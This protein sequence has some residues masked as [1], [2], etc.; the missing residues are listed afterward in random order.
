MAVKNDRRIEIDIVANDKASKSVDAIS[1]TIENRMVKAFANASRGSQY[2]TKS[3]K[4]M[5]QSIKSS[6]M[7]LRQKERLQKVMQSDNLKT[8]RQ[9]DN[10]SESYKRMAGALSQSNSA[11][12]KSKSAFYMLG[13]SAIDVGGD[14]MQVA[15]E[16]AISAGF[17]STA[18]VGIS[19]IDFIHKPLLESITGLE[20]KLI[21]LKYQSFA[22]N[23]Q[24][25][26]LRN[27][28]NI[29]GGAL[30]IE[31]SIEKFHRFERISKVITRN[32]QRFLTHMFRQAMS[33]IKSYAHAVDAV[34][35]KHIIGYQLVGKS[36]G[37]MAT[38]MSKQQQLMNS[39]SYMWL[40]FNDY[41]SENIKL[42]GKLGDKVKQSLSPSMLS[43]A[44]K[45]LAYVSKAMKSTFNG[46]IRT[47]SRDVPANL[48]ALSVTLRRTATD[49]SKFKGS[50]KAINAVVRDT[51]KAFFQLGVA[52]KKV[53]WGAVNPQKGGGADGKLWSRSG[54]AVQ[55][56]ADSMQKLAAII[57]RLAFNTLLVPLS[58]IRERFPIVNKQI[59]LASV[60]MSTFFN[61]WK[62][63]NKYL[64]EGSYFL[65]NL[66]DAFK[67]I[68][69]S[70]INIKKSFNN[71]ILGLSEMATHGFAF[72]AVRL[73]VYFQRM[74]MRTVNLSKSL[75]KLGTAMFTGADK[76]KV[77]AATISDSVKFLRTFQG[78]IWIAAGSAYHLA[79]GGLV[80]LAEGFD[81]LVALSDTA[82]VTIREMAFAMSNAHMDLLQ[83]ATSTSL[84]EKALYKFTMKGLNAASDGFMKFGKKVGFVSGDTTDFIL[85]ID[86]VILKL[87][88][89]A[90]KLGTS[91]IKLVGLSIKML[92]AMYMVGYQSLSAMKS[93]E[94]FK[95]T[96]TF[97]LDAA[98]LGAAKLRVEFTRLRSAVS[99]S[100]ANFSLKPFLNQID[101]SFTSLTK[102]NSQMVHTQSIG[103]MK[104]KMTFF[105]DIQNRISYVIFD[106]EVF[107]RK[108]KD[109]M[110]SAGASVK[111]FYN[112][113]SAA[114]A[115]NNSIEYWIKYGVLRAKTALV[116][117]NR[118]G[119]KGTIKGMEILKRS[120]ESLRKVFQSIIKT[121]IGKMLNVFDPKTAIKGIK[122]MGSSMSDFTSVTKDAIKNSEYFHKT[123][124]GVAARATLLS[125]AFG[126][127]GMHMLKSDSILA[128]MSGATLIA[129][130][131]AAGGAAFFIQQAFSKVGA[132]IKK[133]GDALTKSSKEQIKTFAEYQKSAYSFNFVIEGYSKN[134]ADA[135]QQTQMWTK[136]VDELGGKT[137]ATKSSLQLLVAETKAVTDSLG[138]SEKQMKALIERSIDMAEVFHQKPINALNAMLKGMQG[139]GQGLLTYSMHMN[140]H[141]IET[142]N[143]SDEYKKNFD[144]LGHAKQAQARYNVLMQQSSKMSKFAT[145]NTNLYSKSLKIQK[146]ILKDM[147]AELGSG[148]EIVNGRVSE[149]YAGSLR[150]FHGLM[151]PVLPLLG[152]IQAL[153]GRFMQV[154]GFI[155]QNFLLIVALSSA[156]RVFN[157]VLTG[158]ADHGFFKKTLPIGNKNMSE[159]LI[160]W[161]AGTGTVRTLG[162][163][164]KASFGIISKQ[165]KIA[166]KDVFGLKVADEITTKSITKGF[167]RRARA[168]LMMGK[169]QKLTADTVAVGITKR[170]SKITESIKG[171]ASSF[172]GLGKKGSKSMKGLTKSTIGVRAASAAM[173]RGWY[174]AIAGM[175]KAAWAF[176]ISNPIVLAAAA[177][178]AAVMAIGYAMKVVN[179][180]TKIFTDLWNDMTSVLF[181]SMG[182]FNPLIETIGFI[183]R[184]VGRAWAGGAKIAMSWMMLLAK[185]F[186]FVI[187][188]FLNG[189]NLFNKILPN[190]MQI[191]DAA[192]KRVTKSVDDLDVIMK[193]TVKEGFNLLK[194]AANDNY[195]DNLNNDLNTVTTSHL[196]HEL[197]SAEKAIKETF[198][199]LRSFSP[200]LKLDDFEKKTAKMKVMFKE[201]EIASQR[202]L[203]KLA[204]TK[205]TDSKEFEQQKKKHE[206]ILLM[207][208]AMQEKGILESRSLLVAQYQ[209]EIKLKKAM[210]YTAEMEIADLKLKASKSEQE[211]HIVA[212]VN[213]ATIG[214]KIA[215]EGL[216]ND[217]QM[218]AE[219]TKRSDKKELELLSKQLNLKNQMAV[220]KE[221]QRRIL[222][223]Q[224]KVEQLKGGNKGASIDAEMDLLKAKE[225]KRMEIL[226][227]SGSIQAD[228]KRQHLQNLAMIESEAFAQKQELLINQKKIIGDLTGN[229]EESIQI[230]MDQKLMQDEVELKMLETKLMNEQNLEILMEERKNQ[231]K[232]E[233]IIL[234]Q[235]LEDDAASKKKS[236]EK[237]SWGH[238]ARLLTDHSNFKMKQGEDQVKHD[239]KMKDLSVSM[240]KTTLTDMST[241]QLAFGKKGF[242]VAKTFALAKNV[243]DT[244]MGVMNA[245]ANISF[246]ASA[247]V[248]TMIGIKGLANNKKIQSAQ[249]H[250]G[251][252]NIPQSMDNKTFLLK[253]GE[254]VLQPEA[255]KDLTSYLKGNQEGNKTG[256]G[257]T[258]ISITVNGNPDETQLFQMKTAIIEA[259]RESSE[260]GE[261]IINEKGIVRS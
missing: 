116:D 110:L 251:I 56:F 50:S 46:F 247:L 257:E 49:M 244:S 149:M 17:I 246:P 73:S 134:S 147:Y 208:K 30:W 64:K 186:L 127:L 234:R 122:T 5:E 104:T 192:L 157:S 155:T 203:A 120:S 176:V 109:V 16:M 170:M 42:V 14:I 119:I 198:K 25:K 227:G 159:L 28:T 226:R 222:L 96:S 261:P 207:K 205:G 211:N 242:A 12:D 38:Q 74:Y 62:D 44:N 135:I 93:M 26:T 131:I 166:I 163:A 189:I 3:Q 243:I 249:A 160:K 123:I 215:S 141:A 57:P 177:I 53:E 43:F 70:A 97:A 199:T 193:K 144:S 245:F 132:V 180:K 102:F 191:S 171:T 248:A 19:A 200:K 178:I 51:S 252:D 240:A 34:I 85:A 22:L 45:S 206:E 90:Q 13:S 214:R 172:L 86:N 250:G 60:K 76:A 204:M 105:Q 223:A 129:F 99:S 188:T 77:L 52:V 4:S 15:K 196:R 219:I 117:L 238:Y 148:A 66:P 239:Q 217:I 125:G 216:L 61:K 236:D 235:K 29:P 94:D 232:K 107:A 201:I 11:V 32:V 175:A 59:G 142:S 101:E 187:Q 181:D 194:N 161:G 35:D 154:F 241:M 80:A 88:D 79:H 39:M 23:S 184:T 169:Y 151:K 128:K 84:S 112:K 179:D 228:Q 174:I 220:K 231:M 71:V 67:E 259:I 143:L 72:K 139:N 24:M 221:T 118:V 212:M 130:S 185:T 89:K 156:Y 55:G 8:A 31:D 63:G 87:A 27:S 237:K 173:A 190:S 183:G 83:F 21:K 6:N 58:L 195:L 95:D 168:F 20:I 213:K 103:A 48:R 255:N 41:V 140:K 253:G 69:I 165:V 7:S 138:F 108:T 162:E 114:F 82:I 137:G 258:N 224:N 126:A 37:S 2:L 158:L 106:L 202:L 33:P 113:F 10:L 210:T 54:R 65:E 254:R 150:L 229:S 92:D 197:Q 146:N 230:A 256:S 260:R 167:Q 233:N 164:G 81:V 40:D 136:Y 121:N 1:K 182:V 209:H 9:I 133:V 152:F 18:L 111:S 153:I 115:K 145:K 98:K 47:I 124:G 68:S 75:L 225:M 91:M 218:K 78:A 100:F 36:A